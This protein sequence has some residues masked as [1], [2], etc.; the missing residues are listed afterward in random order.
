MA[1][2]TAPA[3]PTRPS[4]TT[5]RAS[6]A[7][8][9]PVPVTDG[10]I[11][12]NVNAKLVAAS[13]ITGKVTNTAATPA[14]L[15]NIEVD[16]YDSGGNLLTS[17]S[18]AADGTYTF[19]GVYAL[20]AGTYRVGFQDLS[21]TYLA[22]FYNGKASLATATAITVGAGATVANVNAK[23]TT[24][25]VIKG[26][27]TN[28]AA[29]PVALA[30]IEVDLYDSSGN[31]L[32][33]TT[34]AADGSYS[35]GGLQTGTYRVGFQD[36]S[37][38]AY[39]A[40]FFNGQATLAAATA[41]SVTAGTTTA[42]VNAKLVA[43]SNITGKVTNTA[44]TPAPLANIEVDL[45]DSGGNLLTSA[46]TAAD[47]TYTF[48][49]VYALA[50]G[51][52][53]VGFQDL[54]GTYLAQFY[55]GKASLATATA[56]TVGAGATVANVNAK[57]T[58]GGVIKGKVTNSAATPV[59]LA[60]IEVDLYDSSGNQ[61]NST[62][63]AADGSYS[64]GGLQTGTY[65]VGFQDSSG[66][67]YVA[68]F[69]N[70]QATLAAATA[71]SVTAGTTTANVNAKL[72]AASN[73]T[74][75]VTNTAATPAPLANIEVDL[76]D[77]GGSILASTTTNSSGSYSFAHVYPL[78][79][80]TYDVGFRD[81][82]RIYL[83]QFYNGQANFATATAIT[84]GAGAT[85]ANVNAKLTTGG[86]IKGTVTNNA[87]TPAPLPNIEVLLYNSA[88]EPLTSTTTASNGTYSF[89]GLQ[90]GKYLVGFEDTTTA[91]YTSQFYAG[92]ATAATA[93][94]V[95]VTAAT[96]TANV[97]VKLVRASNIT[98]KVTN[99][100][101]TPAPL[102]NIE[103]DLYDG[104]DNLLSSTLTT[105]T[106]TY[107]FAGTS[108]LGA[109]TY[110][111]GFQDTQSGLYL[112]QFFSGKA[113]LASATPITVGAS[114]TVAN[115]NAA[116]ALG[117]SITGKA[118]NVSGTGLPG[119]AVTVYDN[120]GLEVGSTTTSATGAYMVPGLAPG[121]YEV[122]F[123]D[124]ANTDVS[125]FY[126]GAHSIAT[127][128]QVVVKTATATTN[129][130]QALPVGGT[131]SGTVTDSSNHPLAGVAATVYDAN[132]GIVVSATTNASGAY[133]IAGLN[134]GAYEVGFTDFSGHHLSVFY[135]GK[136]S[137]VS[138]NTV[139]VTTGAPTTNVNQQ[140]ASSAPPP[141]TGA[142]S[143]LV[144]DSGG[145][146]LAGVEVDA[147]ASS[148]S[149]VTGTQTS[150]AGT[151]TISGL[152]TG[153]YKVGFFPTGNYL[154]LY[155]NGAS[156]LTG[157][158]A[159]SVAA[160]NTTPNINAKLA[161]GGQITGTVTGSGPPVAPLGGVGV[162]LYGSAG[163]ELQVT[164]TAANGTYGFAGLPSGTYKVG[165]NP[166]GT[167][168]LPQYYNSKSSLSTA[169][170]ITVTAG[171]VTST[172]NA[173]LVTGGGITGVVTNSA[174]APQAGI[175]VELFDS[176]GTQLATTATA[177]D[178]SYSFMGL[179]A[180]SYKVGFNLSGD[181][182]FL[183][184][185]YNG[186]SSLT[187][188]TG[189]SVPATGVVSGINAKLV[190]AGRV[191]G[192][193]NDSLGHPLSGITVNVYDGAGNVVATS[194][195]GGDGTYGVNV[196]T[197]GSYR[198]GFLPP[199]GNGGVGS[200]LTQYYSNKATLAG[201][202][203]VS[204]TLGATTPNI[205][206]TLQRAGE[207]SGA[208]TD[209]AGHPLAGVTVT[210][211]SA[212]SSVTSTTTDQGG[213]YAVGGLPAGTY[214]VG[215][216]TG[217][218]PNYTPVYYSGKSTLATATPVAVSAGAVT[219]NINAQLSGRAQI[220]GT[221]TSSSAA[222]ISGAAVT[223]Y[224]SAGQAVASATTN[225]NGTY[226]ATMLDGGSYRVRFSSPGY[227]TQ[228][229][230]NQAT[231]ATATAVSV[232]S[233]GTVTAINARLVAT[234]AI[235]GTVTNNAATPVAIAGVTVTV[236][237]GAGAAVGST[238][239]TSTGTFTITGLT[240]G[241]SAYRVGFAKTGYVTQYYNNQATLAAA[242]TITVSAGATTSAVNAHLAP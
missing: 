110:K 53:R 182:S 198:V 144:T 69:F 214:Q 106:G 126:S 140:M 34:T 19:A 135:S 155:Y 181:G 190:V 167:S 70:G 68:Q 105:S 78:S 57:L 109:G 46:S 93:T 10:A 192:L 154:P 171:A 51:T 194:S 202:T 64:L 116:L 205:N 128:T 176:S 211:Y 225:S 237:N 162:T 224:N 63:T 153:S 108:A 226:T 73:I 129:I 44:A 25:G 104:N 183:S 177:Y 223:V 120:Q 87:A 142:I 239:T 220:E 228:Y 1:S 47:G 227:V 122:G 60:N 196:A 189:V 197:A 86:V 8:A 21:G 174:S 209:V 117:G 178:G 5:G 131:I 97:N 30:N 165:F 188:A 67:A 55:N 231:L 17:A 158:T 74:G 29:T 11:T 20:A 85:V 114:A 26:K 82:S 138:A 111:I 130:S 13:N 54:S 4:S 222:G 23:L 164:T 15:A 173:R 83:P 102:A 62:T 149:L 42:N 148:G 99:T 208:V 179:A 92:Q 49:G 147:F 161:T 2:R 71:V 22:Q 66:R 170:A 43:A 230:N 236:Y 132:G 166:F 6:L 59:A 119:I 103:V 184:Q 3:S 185:Y 151:Y 72:V 65:R 79:A 143:G 172:I 118:V 215:F 152:P 159:V 61:L 52:Y 233:G 238:T 28:S 169:T 56:I 12:Q 112:P 168:Y 76:Y 204:V 160:P 32:N 84:V 100:A 50:A 186:A 141:A 35:L 91:A 125:Y 58:T 199:S 229:Y 175:D 113:N 219:P 201:A 193:V 96:T 9:T 136:A 210:V 145:H 157:A 101:A 89:T 191:T 235:S 123:F 216:D 139:D 90:T 36:S 88:D 241:T 150:A 163:N 94:K 24:G 31:Q 38:R 98:G 156:T 134:A 16:L 213:T 75:K 95:S 40:Q 124:P 200:F 133:S 18:T 212:G 127:A 37:G 232:P 187:S 203:P 121:L 81:N 27:V 137:I 107:T 33:S 7:S 80:G 242:N 39:V 221:V 41:V 146:A 217:G 218:G 115:V 14:P 45:Y 206:A 240:P 48:A 207:I 77:S 195:T 234:G 180:G